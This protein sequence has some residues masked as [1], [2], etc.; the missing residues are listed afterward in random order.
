[1]ESIQRTFTFPLIV[2][3]TAARLVAAMVA[4]LACAVIVSG[5]HAA[6]P[7]LA[8]GF[9]LR[10]LAGPKISPLAL[11]AVKVLVPGLRLPVRPV[12]GAPKRFAQGIG[13]AVTVTA[14]LL[15]LVLHE[16]GAADALLA[17][18]VVFATLESV[19]GFCAGCWLYGVAMRNG[20]LGADACVDCAPEKTRAGRNAA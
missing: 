16:R 15:S 12:A 13:L 4:C 5:F 2:N 1:M 20:W 10:V 9:L 3:E 7:V 17:L 8:V 6:L 14:S 11:L 19:F 18:L